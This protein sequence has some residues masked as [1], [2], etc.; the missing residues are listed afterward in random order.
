MFIV[1]H[2]AALIILFCCCC[3]FSLFFLEKYIKYF[4]TAEFMWICDFSYMSNFFS[5]APLLNSRKKLFPFT[6]QPCSVDQFSLHLFNT[7]PAY[8]CHHARFDLSNCLCPVATRGRVS[9]QKKHF[10]YEGNIKALTANVIFLKFSLIFVVVFEFSPSRWIYFP[11][12]LSTCCRNQI[13]ADIHFR[14]G[15]PVFRLW[16]YSDSSVSAHTIRPRNTF[17]L[18]LICISGKDKDT[19]RG[20]SYTSIIKL[21]IAVYLNESDKKVSGFLPSVTVDGIRYKQ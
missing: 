8:W 3:F 20:K 5:A 2:N 4:P 15:E 1:Q 11:T 6:I 10:K 13:L 18:S 16:W 17:S 7:L 9:G 19:N 12:S 14:D 21:I